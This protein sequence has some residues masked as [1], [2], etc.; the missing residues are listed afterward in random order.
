MV[1]LFGTLG[2]L[3]VLWGFA[4]FVVTLSGASL[5]VSLGIAFWFETSQPFKLVLEAHKWLIGLL[6]AGSLIVS[7]LVGS[8][9]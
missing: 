1:P 5:G 8:F 4:C 9:F 3:Q 7:N 2:I 6:V